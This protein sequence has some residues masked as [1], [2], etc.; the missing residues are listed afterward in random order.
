[1]NVDFLQQL[2]NRNVEKNGAKNLNCAIIGESGSGKSYGALRISE[3]Y[4]E[5]YLNKK[6]PVKNVVFTISEFLERVGEMGTDDKC[7]I[8]IFDDAGLKY[9]SSRWFDELNQILGY[10]LQS[11]RYR[12]INVLFTIPV[13]KWLDRIGRGMLHG[14]IELKSVGNGAYYK[15]KYN[16][17]NDKIYN[18][19]T[20]LI[21]FNMPGKT[22]IKHYE[23][24]K[25]KFLEI[26]YQRYLQE[27]KQREMRKMELDKQ[28]IEFYITK[29]LKSPELYLNKRNTYDWRIIKNTFSLKENASKLIKALADKKRDK[30]HIGLD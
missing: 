30:G 18:R 3:L 15:V 23:A 27:A 10:T 17:F 2:H 19:R 14:K 24:K 22:L 16:Q 5:K 7:S 28:D 20:C 13:L 12:I 21:K 25:H 6:F 9:S 4:Y 1:M 11:Y 8:L 29:L 26:E